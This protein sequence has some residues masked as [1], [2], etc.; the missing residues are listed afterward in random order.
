MMNL[1]LDSSPQLETEN[2]FDMSLL[3][4]KLTES[5]IFF[6]SYTKNDKI[7]TLFCQYF[8]IFC[9]LIKQINGNNEQ[10]YL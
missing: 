5:N 6:S 7:L 9:L 4:S 2:P 3:A 10:N 8:V 1:T